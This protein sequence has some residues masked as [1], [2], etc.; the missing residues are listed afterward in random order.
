MATFKTELQKHLE[1]PLEKGD[2]W[3]LIDNQRFK[4]L[5]KY[6][7]L[8]VT[9]SL[10]SIEHPHATRVLLTTNL[11]LMTKEQTSEIT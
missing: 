4:K 8:D 5:K 3:Y 2:S 7:G 1:K 11:C 6:I 9:E 10:G